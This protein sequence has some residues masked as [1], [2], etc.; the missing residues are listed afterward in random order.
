[1]SLQKQA[2][3]MEQEKS[4][5]TSSTNVV[6]PEPPKV[7]EFDES[8]LEEDDLSLRVKLMSYNKITSTLLVLFLSFVAMSLSSLGPW[9]GNVSNNLFQLKASKIVI[10]SMYIFHN[11]QG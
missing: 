11:T 3:E 2:S 9:K 8:A 7:V 5:S 10:S 6:F 4:T 1:M